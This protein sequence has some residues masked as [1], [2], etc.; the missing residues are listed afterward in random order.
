VEADV[1]SPAQSPS[2]QVSDLSGAGPGCRDWQGAD[3]F[4]LVHKQ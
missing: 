2:R 3:R 4:A 1:E